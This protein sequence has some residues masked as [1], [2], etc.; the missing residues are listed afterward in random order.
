M[1]ASTI[2]RTSATR[3]DHAEDGCACGHSRPMLLAVTALLMWG[4]ASALQIGAL[5]RPE[6]LP[7]MTTELGRH[8]LRDAAGHVR[9]ASRECS[10]VA[11]R[12]VRQPNTLSRHDSLAAT[13]VTP[14][15]SHRFRHGRG[16]NARAVPQHR[17]RS[18]PTHGSAWTTSPYA[19][20]AGRRRQLVDYAASLALDSLFITDL[21]AF[22]S[23]EE[24]PL[25]GAARVRRGAPRAAAGGHLEHLPDVEGVQ[26]E[27]G[28]C[29]GT[30]GARHPGGASG[31]FSGASRGARH[32]GRPADGRRHRPA[33][34]A[35]G[36]GL[37]CGPV[38]GRGRRREDRRREP[39][40]RH[41]LHRARAAG[42]GG[43][44][45]L[46]GRE[47]RFGQ[48]AVDARGPDRVP[49][50]RWPG[51]RSPR[52]CATRRCGYPR[53]APASRGRRWARAQSISGRSSPRFRELCPDVPVHIE[54]ISGF[55]REL[56]YLQPDFWKA[57]PRIA[58]ARAGPIRSPRAQGHAVASLA[59]ALRR[60][61]GEGGAGLPAGRVGAVHPLLQERA[62]AGATDE[63]RLTRPSGTEAVGS[64][65]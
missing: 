62:E 49:A 21:D 53:T 22:E 52:A 41:A 7:H 27:V 8:A 5:S 10:V 59:G 3:G 43:R 36:E 12:P 24:A 15:V 26:A 39:R 32:L 42:R 17:A 4:R 55:N 31:G 25:Q 13:G 40:R 16:R 37:P 63:G 64:H 6:G 48:R 19:P 45:R 1:T 14:L 34:R 20:W 11:G 46:R 60:R 2:G 58:G 47:L 44:H 54:T 30:P 18:R 61:Q 50:R 65:S 56:P 28:H 38:A 35:D 29:R 9:P 51:T 57:W 23:L 33:H